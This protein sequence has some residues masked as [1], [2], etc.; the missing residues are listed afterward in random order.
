MNDFSKKEL[1]VEYA[2]IIKKGW[3]HVIV[4]ALWFFIAFGSIV[5]R[6]SPLFVISSLLGMTFTGLAFWR[7][8][9]AKQTKELIIQTKEVLKE[10]EHKDVDSLQF[11]H[12]N[13]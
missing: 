5:F 9:K 10:Q 11:F 13:N 8:R 12:K 4:S 6:L 2:D 3:H 7:F 1:E